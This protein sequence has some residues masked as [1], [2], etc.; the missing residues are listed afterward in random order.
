MFS[1]AVVAPFRWFFFGCCFWLLVRRRS[2][3]KHSLFS[4]IRFTRILRWHFSLFSNSIIRSS[5]DTEYHSPHLAEFHAC[6]LSCCER[7]QNREEAMQEN[8]EW[9]TNR[10]CENCWFFSHLGLNGK[11]R[12]IFPNEM[13]DNFPLVIFENF[14]WRATLDFPSS[15]GKWE[16]LRR[17]VNKLD[18]IFS[19]P[20]FFFDHFS[21]FYIWTFVVALIIFS[22]NRS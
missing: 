14:E 7:N 10:K 13:V 15:T 20:S 1:F 11:E 2:F 19:S 6:L 17:P 18:L 12:N 9:K 4:T 8:K 16:S 5:T 21:V 3:S 22:S